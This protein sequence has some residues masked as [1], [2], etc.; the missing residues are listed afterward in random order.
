MDKH[1]RARRKVLVTG[2]SSGI[3]KAIVLRLLE[4]GHV[5]VGVARDF[6]KFPH[7]HEAFE[8]VTLDLSELDRLPGALQDLSRAHP[9]IDT[10]VCNAG[11][12]RFGCLEEFSYTQIRHSLD[13]NFLNHAYVVRAFLPNLKRHGGGDIVFIGS[14]TAL[15]G[16]R[17]G[18]VYSA[19]KFALRGFAQALR[20]ECAA[21]RVRVGLINPGMVKTP[22]FDRLN[23]QP[24]EDEAHYVLPDDVADAVTLMLVARDGT[25]FDEINLSP[26]KKVVRL[27]KDER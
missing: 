23:F 2:A 9:D 17:R 4:D 14:E 22:F 1:F 11:Q 3:G 15:A 19:A 27:R 20:Q 26:L 5:V 8:T 25:V 18:A 12:G 6:Q 16:G 24:G 13:L 21:S 10:L 7:A